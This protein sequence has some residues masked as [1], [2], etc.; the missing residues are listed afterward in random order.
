MRVYK[1]GGASAKDGSGIRNLADLASLF[2]GDL[3]I[4]VS[5]IGK[6]TDAPEKVLSAFDLS[7]SLPF[8]GLF[9]SRPAVI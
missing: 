3:V 7:V 5:A 2:S 6:T 1:P 8:P 9:P 4:V